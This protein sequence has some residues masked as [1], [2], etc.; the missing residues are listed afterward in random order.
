MYQ[1]VRQLQISLRLREEKVWLACWPRPVHAL[2]RC[3]HAEGSAPAA[4]SESCVGARILRVGSTSLRMPDMFGGQLR[5]NLCQCS[6]CVRQSVAKLLWELARQKQRV[7]RRRYVRW[8]AWNSTNTSILVPSGAI[9]LN[10]QD[11]LHKPADPASAAAASALQGL[12]V[13]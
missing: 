6:D 8:M 2:W 12:G 5:A 10:W 11:E 13:C 1:N 4:G 3:N 9:L 7:F